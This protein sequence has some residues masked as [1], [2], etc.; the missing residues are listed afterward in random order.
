[1]LNIILGFLR[2]RKMVMS[3]NNV[4]N[5]PGG[6]QARTMLGL[7]MFVVLI[8]AFCSITP[9]FMALLDKLVRIT[10]KFIH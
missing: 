10:L 4:K 2:D 8:N 7:I 1:M 6:G 9:I 3:F 5:M